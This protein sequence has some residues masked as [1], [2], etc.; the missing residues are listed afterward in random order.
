MPPSLNLVI[1]DAGHDDQAAIVRVLVTAFSA[2]PVARWIDP[3]PV[4]R[5]G[6]STGYFAAA[7]EVAIACGLARLAAE[8][9]DV[10]A[11]ALWLP[12]T[13][14][15]QAGTATPRRLRPPDR[16]TASPA[17]VA[18]W[19]RLHALEALLADR[20]P[21]HPHHHLSFIGVRPDRQGRGIGTYLLDGHHAYLDGLSM[22]AYLE[23]N[24]PRN[25]KLYQRHGYT[26]LGGAL[27]L[28]GGGVRVWPMWR[29]PM[30]TTVVT[31]GDAR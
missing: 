11:A 7:V 1:R 10:V 25:R 19:R 6:H 30:R 20:H 13:E 15:A 28:P 9:G 4:S 2:G 16:R 31:S 29:E 26:D 27:V 14:T 21:T 8:N 12:H 23:A 18:A 17:A 5:D 3:D 22:P 24:D